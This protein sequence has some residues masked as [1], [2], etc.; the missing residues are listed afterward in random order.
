MDDPL[1]MLDPDEFRRMRLLLAL[2][3]IRRLHTASLERDIR[4]AEKLSDLAESGP[5]AAR[6]DGQLILTP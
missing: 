2:A 4:E 1:E 3:E 5:R 6:K